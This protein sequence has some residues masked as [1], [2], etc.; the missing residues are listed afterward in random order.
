MS[1]R[2]I[3][4]LWRIPLC[5]RRRADVGGKFGAA[6]IFDEMCAQQHSSSASHLKHDKKQTYTN[7][8]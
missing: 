6:K 8:V 1:E 5:H 4:P 7:C 3:C 2:F